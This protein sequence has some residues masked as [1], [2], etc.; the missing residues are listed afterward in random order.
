MLN[1][2]SEEARVHPLRVTLCFH[3]IGE[4]PHGRSEIEKPYWV[5][6][7][8]LESLLHNLN[9]LEMRHGADIQLDFDDANESDYFIVLPMLKRLSKRAAF[10]VPT[11]RLDQS[12][13][14]SC[15]HV[16]H[17]ASEGMV[18]GSHGTD[19]VPWTELT[20]TE[21]ARQLTH[22]KKILED[23][24]GNQVKGAAAPHG[25]WSPR[26]VSRVLEAGYERLH[27]CGERPCQ[28][29]GMLNHRIVVR[30]GD[31]VDTVL[32]R[33][34]KI[35]RRAVHRAKDLHDKLLVTAA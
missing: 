20:D 16:K 9:A 3:G 23:L 14:L 29:Y 18:L 27:T 15:Q 10:F 7:Q 1:N 28:H 32:S 13:Y 2:W 30:R 26:V 35:L 31:D 24:S 12:T 33:K 5:S 8:E 11:D 22:S 17:L 21:L 19:H 34:L 6:S 4:M 25:L